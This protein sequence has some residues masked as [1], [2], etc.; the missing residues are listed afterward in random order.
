MR[1]WGIY[2]SA[3][4]AKKLVLPMKNG[5]WSILFDIFLSVALPSQRNL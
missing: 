3:S 1:I 2:L 4:T 5:C